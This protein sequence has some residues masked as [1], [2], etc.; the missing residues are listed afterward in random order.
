MSIFKP[1][2]PVLAIPLTVW[3]LSVPVAE[4]FF[5]MVGKRPSDD[6][7]GLYETFGDGGYKHA[8]HVMTTANWYTGSFAVYTDALGLRCG[9]NGRGAVEAGD[10]VDFLLLGD[11]QTFSSGVAYENSIGGTL[12][13]AASER[14]LTVANGAVSGHLLRNQFEM[15][16]WLCE[17]AQL[18][19]RTIVV[20]LTP[21]LM[22]DAASYS[23]AHVAADGRLYD[24][25]PGLATRM[26]TW[27]K[28]HCATY[29]AVRDALRGTT[30][31]DLGLPKVV[32]FFSPQEAAAGRAESL[33]NLLGDMRDWADKAGIQLLFA[34]TALPMEAT[35]ED[36][37]EIA[38]SVQVEVSSQVPWRLAVDVSRQLQ[39]PL[40]DL[41]PALEVVK[42]S[43]QPLQLEGDPFYHYSA[44]TSR[45]CGQ[46]LWTELSGGPTISHRFPRPLPCLA[47][48]E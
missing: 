46:Q 19:V 14:G 43:G 18:Q 3:L 7:Y 17:D 5:R 22:G 25:P 20:M 10:R 40:I 47:Q 27:L 1:A 48:R 33:R 24:R 44:A 41:R 21:H 35:F 6:Q 32:S 36:V 13:A 2:V 45:R 39:V 30:E 37:E 15:A 4:V 42:A 8:P 38:R 26:R 11:S 34:Y 31:A 28:T 9:A 16:R 23:R 29:I 12:Q